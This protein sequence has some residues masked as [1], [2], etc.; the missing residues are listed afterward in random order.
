MDEQRPAADDVARDM[1]RRLDGLGNE[2]KDAEKARRTVD[3]DARIKNAAGDQTID[4]QGEH[5]RG[6]TPRSSGD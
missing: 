2:I 4:R 6:G 5:S 3:E 1:E